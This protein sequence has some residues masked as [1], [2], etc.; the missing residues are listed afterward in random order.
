MKKVTGARLAAYIIDSLIVALIASLFAG[1]TLINPNKEKM[2]ELEEEYTTSTIENFKNQDHSFFN[3]SNIENMTYEISY[4]GI[5]ASVIELVVMFLYFGLFQYYNK[6]QTIGKKLLKI[7]VVSTNKKKLK[8]YQIIIRSGIIN[9]LLTSSLAIIGLL[10]L[11]KASFLHYDTFVGLLNDGLE[12]A[13]IIM[14]LYRSD[15]I[16]LHDLLAST[17]VISCADRELFEKENNIKEAK[18]TI[19]KAKKEIE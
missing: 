6:G 16:G 13:C 4:Y 15:G 2:E 14:I 1:I 5:Y 8:L 12:I 11:S 17:R 9:G 19:K 7:E 10:Y 18:V 3:D